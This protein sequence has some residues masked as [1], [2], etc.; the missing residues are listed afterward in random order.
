MRLLI[1]SPEPFRAETGA[2]QLAAGLA[3]SLTERG[4]AVETWASPPVPGSVPSRQAWRWRRYR[5]AEHLERAGPFTVVDLPPMMADG[6]VASRTSLIVRSIQPELS[7][8]GCSLWHQA[9]TP[10]RSPGPLAAATILSLLSAGRIL[11][12]WSLADVLLCLGPA[13]QRMMG[14]RFPWLRPKLASYLA[15]PPPDD[16]RVLAEVRRRRRFPDPEA[17]VR[18]LWL[19]RWSP[20][21]GTRRLVDFIASRA[22]SRPRDRFTIAGCGEQATADLPPDLLAAG[23]LRVVPRYSRAQLPLLLS[24]HD[25]GLFTSEAEGWG[26][27]LQEMVESGLPVYATTAGVVEELR[28]LLPAWVRPFPPP[29]GPLELATDPSPEAFS[30]YFG[31]CSW[32]AVGDAYEKA[33]LRAA[34][35][36]S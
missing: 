30:R 33:V 23:T 12:S 7:Y 16:R 19:G 26:L 10:F 1:A 8:L 32:T 34:R 15:A 13:E 3:R 5:L 9:R 21:K 36:S 4:H 2:G 29:N 14:R 22:A 6:R 17:G 25:A 31:W 27:S 28:R 18:F 24:S 35:A 11:R 20:H